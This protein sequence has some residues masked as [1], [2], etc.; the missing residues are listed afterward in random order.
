ME[1]D[2]EEGQVVSRGGRMA[3]AVAQD[4]RDNGHQIIN[5]DIAAT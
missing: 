3:V 1:G 2:E 5:V 4:G